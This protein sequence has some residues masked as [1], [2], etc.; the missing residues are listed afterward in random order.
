MMDEDIFI[1]FYQ[2]F[3]TP[4]GSLPRSLPPQHALAP[5]PPTQ[6]APLCC[7]LVTPSPPPSRE[8]SRGSEAINLFCW[9]CYRVFTGTWSSGGGCPRAREGWRMGGGTHQHAVGVSGWIGLPVMDDKECWE[10]FW[11]NSYR[12]DFPV[13]EYRKFLHF[14]RYSNLDGLS[15]LSH[16]A[17]SLHTLR[18]YLFY[19]F[20][21]I[22]P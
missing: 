18:F 5:P 3:R 22:A 14:S 1:H 19:W 8:H 6:V 9:W 13:N 11:T 2:R 16:P 20:M 7:P 4:W 15:V 10:M 17:F 21:T 12:C